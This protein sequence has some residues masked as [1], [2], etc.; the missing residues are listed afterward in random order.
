MVAVT[1]E[2]PRQVRGG[3]ERR[4]GSRAKAKEMPKWAKRAIIGGIVAVVCIIIGCLV[5]SKVGEANAASR[6]RAKFKAGCEATLT[7]L[8]KL[9]PVGQEYLDARKN[10]PKVPWQPKRLEAAAL[11][12]PADLTVDDVLILYGQQ[13]VVASLSGAPKQG[14]TGSSE[15]SPEPR[16][17]VRT[18]NYSGGGGAISWFRAPL[19]LPSGFD[20]LYVFLVLKRDE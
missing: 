18:G 19:D 17:E 12:L 11:G 1:P 2:V 16:V 13:T 3:S 7:L 6:R 9:K 14:M 4:L 15:Q 10:Q 20:K 8:E 5:A